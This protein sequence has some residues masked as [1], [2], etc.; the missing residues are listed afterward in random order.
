M[1]TAMLPTK[2]DGMRRRLST[3][4][5]TVRPSPSYQIIL[6]ETDHTCPALSLAMSRDGSSGGVIRMCVITEGGVERKFVPGD[7]LPTF[8]EGREV[9]GKPASLK[10]E[11]GPAPMA[12]E[13][14]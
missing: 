2:K 1:A 9:L 5:K 13:P 12:V 4:S 11:T 10:A 14:V 7:K 3:S 8:W 6:H